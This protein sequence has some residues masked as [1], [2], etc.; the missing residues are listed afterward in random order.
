M[1]GIYGK[2][3]ENTEI[4]DFNPYFDTV[5]EHQDYEKET[6]TKETET[7]TEKETTTKENTTTTNKDNTFESETTTEHKTTTTKPATERITTDDMENIQ[8]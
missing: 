1:E 2:I 3:H 4:I 8:L 6:T 7:S 5:P